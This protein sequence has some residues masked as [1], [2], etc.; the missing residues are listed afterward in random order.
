MFV[1]ECPGNADACVKAAEDHCPEYGYLLDGAILVTRKTEPY[2][3]R[4]AESGR[5]R[6]RCVGTMMDTHR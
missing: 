4:A 1:A 5:L 6:L 2:A 3:K